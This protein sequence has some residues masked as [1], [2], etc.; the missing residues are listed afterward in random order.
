MHPTILSFFQRTTALLMLLLIGGFLFAQT[1]RIL[2]FSK[3]TVFRHS[4][5]DPGK[6]ALIKM[7]QSKGFAVDTT[8]N[9]A[10]FNEA[11]LKQYAAVV[12]LCT[13]G[14][15]LDAYVATTRLDV[16]FKSV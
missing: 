8:E 12:F 10:K 11:N 13:T 4:S 5:I 6:I 1:P 3:T 15:V 14:D 2:V 7:G 9:S 16:A